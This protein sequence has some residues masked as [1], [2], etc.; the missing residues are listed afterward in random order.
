[1]AKTVESI[2]G[3]KGRDVWSVDADDSVF[4]ALVFMAEKNI[5]ATLVVRDGDLVGIMSERDYARKII[6]MSRLS[7]E[8]RVSEIMTPACR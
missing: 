2:L 4:E 5:G 3:A 1:M 7:K 8:T 6:L